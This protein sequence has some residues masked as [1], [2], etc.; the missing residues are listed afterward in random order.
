MIFDIRT[1][2]FMVG[3]VE[4]S[5]CGWELVASNEPTILAKH[6]SRNKLWA[7]GE[8]IQVSTLD[9]KTRDFLHQV[10]SLT[11][12]GTCRSLGNLQQRR[13]PIQLSHHRSPCNPRFR[14][15]RT[16]LGVHF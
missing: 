1:S 14:H 12:F 3:P 6:R 9:A 13:D 16:R 7:R 2:N 5:E 4:M 15:N 8:K 10:G 11:L